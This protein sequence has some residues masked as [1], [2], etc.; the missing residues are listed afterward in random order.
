M[1][2]ARTKEEMQPLCQRHLWRQRGGETPWSFLSWSPLIFRQ[3]LPP[4]GPSQK[5]ADTRVTNASGA[6]KSWAKAAFYLVRNSTMC[7]KWKQPNKDTRGPKGR[8]QRSVEFIWSKSWFYRWESKEENDVT[9]PKQWHS[10]LWAA[11][12]P[13]ISFP[14]HS[15]FHNINFTIIN[16]RYVPLVDF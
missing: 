14:V 2:G 11:W 6:H 1:A 10:W 12:N 8:A 3:C 16:S 7:W 15:S 9:C 4:A 13:G 5:P